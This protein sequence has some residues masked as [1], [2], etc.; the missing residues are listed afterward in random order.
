MAQ[1]TVQLIIGQILT[2][3]EFRS[4]FLERPIQI[5]RSLRER[6]VELTNVEIDAL[7]QIDRRFWLIGA[8]WIDARLQR[9]RLVGGEEVTAFWRAAAS[10]PTTSR[11]L[12][13]R[14]SQKPTETMLRTARRSASGAARSPAFIQPCTRA[15]IGSHSTRLKNPAHFQNQVGRPLLG[16]PTR[17]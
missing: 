12:A 8:E 1:R 4:D 16:P 5:L 2:D 10:G 14:R 17:G 3:E 13:T 6:G 7:A 9:C 15:A 11:L